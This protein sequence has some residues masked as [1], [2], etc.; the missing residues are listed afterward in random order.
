M[1]KRLTAALLCGMALLPLA[2]EA[3]TTPSGTSGIINAPSGY[4]RMPGHVSAGLD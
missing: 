3:K 1:R 4:V 2:A